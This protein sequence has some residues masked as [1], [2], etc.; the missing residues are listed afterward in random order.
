MEKVFGGIFA[1]FAI[2]PILFSIFFF[3]FWGFLVIFLIAGFVLW[4]L[5]IVDI[6][7]R[8]FEKE[9]DKIMWIIVVA[10]TGIVGSIIYYV[11][12]KRKDKK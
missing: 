2:I 9:D 6:I 11:M 7:N 12:V 1:L 3:I 5:M 4:I 8:D 10:L